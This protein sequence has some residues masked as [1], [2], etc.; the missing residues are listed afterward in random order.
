MVPLKRRAEWIVLP[1]PSKMKFHLT[2]DKFYPCRN[3]FLNYFYHF[4]T[5]KYWN[6]RTLALWHQAVTLLKLSNWCRFCSSVLFLYE[7]RQ[8]ACLT[9]KALAGC[10][11][12][13][14]FCIVSVTLS[15]TNI[16]CGH[17]L[18]ASPAPIECYC[19]ICRYSSTDNFATFNDIYGEPE[20]HQD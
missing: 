13:R 19:L 12:I 7:E 20:C 9:W 10:H 4:F 11:L 15:L 17:T 3:E 2:D 14:D 16:G 6:K 1:K 5:P 8:Y 18:A